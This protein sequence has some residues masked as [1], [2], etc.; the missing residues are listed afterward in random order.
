MDFL[1]EFRDFTD[2]RDFTPDLRYF[3]S[4]YKDYR[5]FREYTD[6]FGSTGISETS[7]RISEHLCAPGFE[8]SLP[9][10]LKGSN[11]VISNFLFANFIFIPRKI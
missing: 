1:P 3:I 8:R 2:L 5:N 4:D 6:I 10:G 9:L 7:G 11:P